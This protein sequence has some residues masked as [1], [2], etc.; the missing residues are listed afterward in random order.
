MT[1]ILDAE[2]TLVE[3]IEGEVVIRDADGDEVARMEGGSFRLLNGYTAEAA[4]GEGPAILETCR[5]GPNP[6]T[7]LALVRGGDGRQH[8]ISAD[9]FD[10]Y[11]A[12]LEAV[13]F[14]FGRP[15]R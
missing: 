12:A 2:G 8:C 1:R 13:G 3:E 4:S 9:S 14:R 6:E 7:R 10:A 15:S 5:P 11:V